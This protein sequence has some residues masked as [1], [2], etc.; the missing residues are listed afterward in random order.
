LTSLISFGVATGRAIKTAFGTAALLTP[1]GWTRGTLLISS[2]ASRIS[3]AD[4]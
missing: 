2:N 4:W 3:F 1:P